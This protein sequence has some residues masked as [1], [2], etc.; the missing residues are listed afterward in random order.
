MELGELI[1]LLYDTRAQRLVI[2]KQVDD[3]KAWETELRDA[4]RVALDR[5]GLQ[6]A[7]GQKATCGLKETIIPIVNDWLAIQEY[8]RTE[9]RFD[10]LQKRLSAPAWRDL[11]EEGILVP[12]TEE[13]IDYDLSLTKSTRG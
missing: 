6:K 10:L 12:G 7:S 5:V 8:I 11:K 1:D 9:N 3:F 4:I 13:G 2:S